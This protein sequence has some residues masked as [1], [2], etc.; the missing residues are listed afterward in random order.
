MKTFCINLDRRPDRLQHMTTQFAAAGISF[1]R[2]AALDALAPEVAAAATH[3]APGMTGRKISAGAYGCF[4]SHRLTW[5]RLVASGDSHA[6]VFEDD[7]VLSDGISA[8]L[9][10]GWIPADADVVKLE[11]LLTRVHLGR[12]AGGQ[13]RGRGLFRLHSRH[14][15]TGGYVISARAAA[16]LLDLTRAVTDPIDELLFNHH[17]P[18][19]PH[20]VTYQMV[21]APVIQGEFSRQDAGAWSESSIQRRFSSGPEAAKTERENAVTRL[22]RR[23]REELRAVFQGTRY[24]VVPFG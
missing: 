18:L 20:L 10:P 3:C 6:M 15:G 17:S 2:I 4:Q 7:L 1:E 9:S 13:A 8:Y 24:V 14:A 5:Q 21:P 23:L 16:R 11:T 12:T 19:F 22:Q